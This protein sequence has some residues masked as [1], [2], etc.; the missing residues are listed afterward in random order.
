M[1]LSL[2]TFCVILD[3]GIHLHVVFIMFAQWVLIYLVA[4]LF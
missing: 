4:Y 2:L 3:I 1:E